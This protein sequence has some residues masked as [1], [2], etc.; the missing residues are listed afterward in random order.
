MNGTEDN[1]ISQDEES[2]S[3]EDTSNVEIEHDTLDIESD[4]EFMA[5]YDV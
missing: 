3:F 2:D 1:E 4:E 5:F